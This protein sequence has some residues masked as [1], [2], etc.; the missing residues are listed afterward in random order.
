MKLLRID[1]NQ[2]VRMLHKMVIALN[3]NRFHNSYELSLNDLSWLELNIDHKNPQEIIIYLTNKWFD[4]DK[5][6]KDKISIASAAVEYTRKNFF[7]LYADNPTD[8]NLFEDYIKLSPSLEPDKSL[9][10]F[11]ELWRG[12]TCAELERELETLKIKRQD[13]RRKIQSIGNKINRRINDAPRGKPRGII[14]RKPSSPWQAT[15]NSAKPLVKDNH[16]IY[17]YEKIQRKLD[18][19]RSKIKPI[20]SDDHRFAQAQLI[21]NANKRRDKLISNRSI[22][23][24]MQTELERLDPLYVDFPLNHL[25]NLPANFILPLRNLWKNTKN[26]KILLDKARN[27]I[28]WTDFFQSLDNYY[29]K[30]LLKISGE[31]EKSIAEI[32]NLWKNGNHIAM[33]ILAIVVTEGIIWN[34]AQ[35]LNRKNIRIFKKHKG[36]KYP[37]L[38]DKKNTKYKSINPKTKR[39]EYSKNYRDRLTSLR[40]LM[41]KTRLGEFLEEDVFNFLVADYYDVRNDLM[42]GNF[43]QIEFS[44]EATAALLALYGFLIDISILRR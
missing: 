32:Q 42:H 5:R 31:H 14:G 36:K 4:E 23:Y 20:I 41:K 34:F 27:D 18:E 39:P 10:L 15:G 6:P 24:W 26:R 25:N 16:K 28:D 17:K 35:Y 12:F 13:L 37:Y 40:D 8:R 43:H 19:L 7:S 1:V 3:P 2:Q 38:W 11:V 33:T 21:F 22:N 30:N 9:I 44:I 29:A